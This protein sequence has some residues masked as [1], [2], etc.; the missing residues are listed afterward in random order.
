MIAFDKL[1]PNG[2]QKKRIQVCNLIKNLRVISEDRLKLVKTIKSIFQ[3][4]HLL[5]HKTY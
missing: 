5:M 2:S 3:P 1:N 4:V